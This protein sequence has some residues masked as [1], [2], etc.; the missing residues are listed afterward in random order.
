MISY[1]RS[2]EEV[3]QISRKKE[4]VIFCVF[5]LYFLLMGLVLEPL[6]EILEGLVVIIREPDFLI[7]DYVEL[8]G[9]GAAFVNASLTTLMC[10]GIIYF[11]KMEVDG[12][13][14]TAIFLMMGFS[15]FGKNIINIWAIL[16]GVWI[17]AKYHRQSV[18]KYIYVGFYG[19]SLSPIITQII[20]TSGLSTFW[21]LIL[22]IIVGAIMGFVLPPLSTHLFYAHQGYSL[23]NSG[24]AAG[25]IA[26]VVVSIYKSFGNEMETRMIWSSG[27]NTL[28]T[29]ILMVFFVMLI[30]IAI[31]QESDITKKYLKLL[32]H[33]G[34]SGTD[35][36]T[37]DNMGVT[38]FNMGINGIFATISVLLVGGELNGPTIG[39][40][41]TIVGFSATGKH[42]RNIAPIMLGVYLASLVSSW[43]ITDPSPIIAFLFA[44]TLAPI[45]GEFGVIAGIVAGFIHV[46]V[47]LNVG[48]I[49]GGMC[50]YNNGFAGGIVAAFFVPVIQSIQDR[51]ARA[52]G[53]V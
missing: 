2:H 23:Y 40:I 51:R 36:L 45:A 16:I 15:L 46:S 18:S 20:Q 31:V 47:A 26:T 8:G 6:P 35:F 38:L 30:I 1:E 39:G 3:R 29:Q 11:A 12:H 21:S 48:V 49:Y 42:L 44:T 41:F 25:I 28:F 7:T 50:L 22:G 27:N 5:P 19:T 9:M 4:F 37:K 52:K 32:K 24:F 10:I 43:S 53:I 33:T 14:I 17:Y 34:R 13:A